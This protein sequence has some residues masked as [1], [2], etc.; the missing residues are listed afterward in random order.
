M[1][2][3]DVVAAGFASPDGIGKSNS[4]FGVWRQK[5]NYNWVPVVVMTT[6]QLHTII[7]NALKE[8][9]KRATEHVEKVIEEEKRDEP[10]TDIEGPSNE[11]ITEGQKPIIK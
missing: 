4:G 5:W 2:Q 1:P 3:F 6:E 9:V 8:Q 11:V 7:E 10:N